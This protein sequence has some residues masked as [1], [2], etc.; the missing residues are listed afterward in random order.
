MRKERDDLEKQIHHLNE[1]CE[2]KQEKWDKTKGKLLQQLQDSQG[3]SLKYNFKVSDSTVIEIWGTIK[4]KIGQWVDKNT[5]T[6]ADVADC[7][8]ETRTRL[9]ACS[10]NAFTFL[11]SRDLSP[12]VFEALLWSWLDDLVF[13][14]ASTV[15]AGSL[16]RNLN[17]LVS[18]VQGSSTN[19]FLPD[20]SSL[21]Y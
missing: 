17:Q 2:Q 7:N 13:A 6:V 16:G 11:A 8:M 21:I 5:S 12:L 15:W 3:L 9:Q 14:P 20:K 10:P 4:H 1:E 18:Q 19:E